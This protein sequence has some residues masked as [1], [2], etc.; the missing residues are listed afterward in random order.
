MTDDAPDD[1]E[2][3]SEVASEVASDADAER[4][5]IQRE[6]E[7]HYARREVMWLTLLGLALVVVGGLGTWKARWQTVEFR[8]VGLIGDRVLQ[9][10]YG[11]NAA[12]RFDVSEHDDRIDIALSERPTTTDDC[13]NNRCVELRAPLGQR[14]VVN[15]R[16]KQDAVV[17]VVRDD[18]DAGCIGTRRSDRLISS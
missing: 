18:R 5:R 4:A 10:N 12:S 13:L 14:R 16:T 11:C 17:L 2:I 7:R 3:A 15:E 6:G 1:G 9:V 8:E